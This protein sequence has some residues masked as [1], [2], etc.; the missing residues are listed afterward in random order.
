MITDK[1][2]LLAT[3]VVELPRKEVT[4]KNGMAVKIQ[5]LKGSDVLRVSSVDNLD[6]K[7]ALAIPKG[8]VEP[9]LSAREVQKIIDFNPDMA[10]EIFSAI[11]ELSNALGEAEVQEAEDAKKN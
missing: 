11:M 2:T 3:C 8:I 5:A 9:S 10:T 4:L 6:D 7:L 1:N